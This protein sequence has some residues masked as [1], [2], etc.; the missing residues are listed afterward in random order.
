MEASP[1]RMRRLFLLCAL[2]QLLPVWLFYPFPN[3]DG[4]S[5]LHNVM[6]LRE[7]SSSPLLQTY[8]E[9]RIPF[10]TNLTAHGALWLLSWLMPLDVAQGVL[11]SGV[12]LAFVFAFRATVTAVNPSAAPAAFLAFPLSFHSF[13][14]FGFWNF[15]L[16]VALYLASVAHVLKRRPGKRWWIVIAVWTILLT[17]THP[18]ALAAALLTWAMILYNQLSRRDA[19]LSAVLLAVPA[20]VLLLF[21][22]SRRGDF[23]NF[24][25]VAD[26]A[27]SLLFARWLYSFVQAEAVVC[28]LLGCLLISTA[29]WYGR[30]HRGTVWPYNA[31][32]YFLLAVVAPLIVDQQLS[33]RLAFFAT[34]A[35]CCWIAATMPVSALRYVAGVAVLLAI[36]LLGVR[37]TTYRQLSDQLAEYSTLHSALPAGSTVLSLCYSPLGRD[38]SG[39]DLSFKV[40]A[41]LHA[42]GLMTHQ[43]PLVNLSNYE[44]GSDHFPVKF[45]DNLSPF[46]Y[47][48]P[49]D[50]LKSY[51]P[52]ADIAAY[53]RLTTGRVD[54]V[55]L[56]DLQPDHRDRP[57]V[58]A[59]F[60]ELQQNYERTAISKP[61]GRGH[62][63][64][65]FPG[66]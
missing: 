16:G 46:R 62:L 14:H 17:V 53:H 58:K 32:A 25:G 27:R 21:I 23:R 41:M 4:P 63:Y 49:M 2:A 29:I 36:G 12:L 40:P 61:A 42:E 65:R 9:I 35:L 52:G 38:A 26:A 10:A 1:V 13:L 33:K 51:E 37:S 31:A 8:Y 34:L 5:H 20:A 11:I 48:A 47:I 39:D 19:I 3:V 54:Y 43:K 6:V 44:A 59:I 18:L 60:A 22:Y 24:A 50:T 57:E 56:W 15:S 66:R 7:W 28:G 64:R 45:R 30:R 55:V